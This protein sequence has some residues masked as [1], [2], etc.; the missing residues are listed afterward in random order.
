M[1]YDLLSSFIPLA[2]PSYRDFH[3][4]LVPELSA[5]QMLGVRMPALRKLAR[6]LATGPGFASHSGGPQS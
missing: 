6:Q 4:K 2:E 3:V 1:T 5:G